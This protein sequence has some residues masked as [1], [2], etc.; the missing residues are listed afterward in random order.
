MCSIQIKTH[1]CANAC[2]YVILHKIIATVVDFVWFGSIAREKATERTNDDRESENGHQANNHSSTQAIVFPTIIG[3]CYLLFVRRVFVCVLFSLFL[4]PCFI[5]L[6][7]VFF[8]LGFLWFVSNVVII[9]VSSKILG[10]NQTMFTIATFCG[11]S[12]V[13][14]D[15]RGWR[16]THPERVGWSCHHHRHHINH[17]CRHSRFAS[18]S[19][20]CQHRLWWL[21]DFDD[22]F[23]NIRFPLY[24]ECNVLTFSTPNT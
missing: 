16:K 14:C 8:C 13:R 24:S 18:M 3:L 12:E 6:G 5:L 4:S 20:L 1:M 10:M 9:L 7:T 21:C 2:E 15:A 17:G 23:E 11:S 19:L 22:I